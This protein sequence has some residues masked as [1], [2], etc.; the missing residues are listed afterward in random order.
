MNAFPMAS[1]FGFMLKRFYKLKSKQFTFHQNSHRRSRTKGRRRSRLFRGKNL[2]VFADDTNR[3]VRS[4][5]IFEF[6]TT[7]IWARAV[8]IFFLGGGEGAYLLM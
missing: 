8:G 6:L 5:G 3:L 2:R 7:G 4:Q 1:K